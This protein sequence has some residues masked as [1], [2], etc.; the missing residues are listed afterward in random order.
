VIVDPLRETEHAGGPPVAQA[1]EP[2]TSV[3]P[4]GAASVTVIGSVVVV[5]PVFFTVS[6]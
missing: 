2:E 6:V 1:G 3:V 5:V 4:V